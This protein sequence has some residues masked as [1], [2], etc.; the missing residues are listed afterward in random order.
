[1]SVEIPF[2]LLLGQSNMAGRGD[3]PVLTGAATPPA[4]PNI[5]RFTRNG[6][7]EPAQHPLQDASDPVFAVK[8]DL[9]GGVGPGLTFAQELILQGVFMRIGLLLC[10]KGGI[11]ITAWAK[12][13]PDGLL[14][15]TLRRTQLACQNG[16]RLM[17][18]LIHV[19]EGDTKSSATAQAWPNRFV[20]LVEDL[21]SSFVMPM[22]PIVF[23]QIGQITA[24]RR[25]HKTHGY[26]GWEELRSI[27][28]AMQF[29][30]H[31]AMVST[32]DLLLQP[33]GLHLSAPAQ[34]MLGQ[35]FALAMRS[36]IDGKM[37]A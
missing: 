4:T 3:L 25:M 21:R 11:G 24:E 6:I 32:D 16:G 27:Q 12:D 19:G 17:G 36:L 30:P 28:S 8:A 20:T 35:R 23:A 18:V 9:R 10:A 26:A 14:T 13:A 7:W 33:D 5:M 2:F 29:P 1:M 34:I 37:A 15:E 31:T 22:L